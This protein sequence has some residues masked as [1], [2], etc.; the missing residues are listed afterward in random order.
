MIRVLLLTVLGSVIS[1]GVPAFENCQKV[2]DFLDEVGQVFCLACVTGFYDS[3]FGYTCSA[4]SESCKT[5]YKRPDI[6]KTCH[7]GFIL[8]EKTNSCFACPNGCLRCSNTTLCSIC[9]DYYF[10]SG[11]KLSCTI[12]SDNCLHCHSPFECL[13]CD[14]GFILRQYKG[15]TICSFGEDKFIKTAIV[16]CTLGLMW[17]IMLALC[18]C[19][20][21]N[22]QQNEAQ[23]KLLGAFIGDFISSAKIEVTPEIKTELNPPQEFEPKAIARPQ[24]LFRLRKEDL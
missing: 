4:C 10:L 1:Q 6:C 24:P 5:C 17:F 16:L 15:K 14:A 21:R 7:D 11:D 20:H 18:Y 23:L 13:E 9:K 8:D 3:G 2:S 22:A 12:C 19:T